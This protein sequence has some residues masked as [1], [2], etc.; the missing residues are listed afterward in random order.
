MVH[1]NSNRSN[2]KVKKRGL[3]ATDGNLLM[4]NRIQLFRL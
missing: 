4:G 1:G 3:H 2:M